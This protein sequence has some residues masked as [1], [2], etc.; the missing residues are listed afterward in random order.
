MVVALDLKLD[1]LENG[2]ISLISKHLVA[3]YMTK[4]QLHNS[5]TSSRLRYSVASCE[6]VS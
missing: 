4:F 1:T 6:F 3:F 5:A 2:R